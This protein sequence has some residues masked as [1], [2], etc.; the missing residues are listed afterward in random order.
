MQL[1]YKPSR[2][3]RNSRVGLSVVQCSVTFGAAAAGG[4]SDGAGAGAGVSATLLS[5][6]CAVRGSS[7]I[8]VGCSSGH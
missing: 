8:A 5:G 1:R 2:E 3:S 4:A 6:A 7:A